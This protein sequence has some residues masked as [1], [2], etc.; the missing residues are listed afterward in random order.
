MITIIM[1]ICFAYGVFTALPHF[2]GKAARE[3]P[4]PKVV[5]ARKQAPTKAG[6]AARAV[7]PPR[8]L[9]SDDLAEMDEWLNS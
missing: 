4:P 9:G 1:L 6:R 2:S 5:Q 8:I 3:N 7:P